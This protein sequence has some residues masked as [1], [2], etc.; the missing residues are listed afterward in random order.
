[1]LTSYFT[2]NTYPDTL[3]HIRCCL[4]HTAS[5]RIIFLLFITMRNALE[6]IACWDVSGQYFRGLGEPFYF[7]S[8]VFPLFLLF[9]SCFLS[10]VSVSSIE[11]QSLSGLA[12]SY[13]CLSL[14]WLTVRN[15]RLWCHASSIGISQCSYSCHLIPTSRIR[16][17]IFTK[18]NYS[19][20]LEN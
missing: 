18:Q 8:S 1:M 13:L 12:Q 15:V 10:L 5:W 17:N 16:E 11:V 2:L 14:Y 19:I 20:Q 6:G 9:F 4:K 7:I 3:R